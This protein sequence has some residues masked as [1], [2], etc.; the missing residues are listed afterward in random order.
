VPQRSLSGL[1]ATGLAP[2]ELGTSFNVT[3]AREPVP[4]VT[5]HNTPA[6]N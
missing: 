2:G 4:A 6:P 1:L 5:V 3:L